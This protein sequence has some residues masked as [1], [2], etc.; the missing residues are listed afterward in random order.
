MPQTLYALSASDAKRTAGPTIRGFAYQFD[1][2]ILRVLGASKGEVVRVEGLEDVD[3]FGNEVTSSV[4]VKYYESRSFTPRAFREPILQMLKSYAAGRTHN[5][6]L[7]V[8]TGRASAP[9][10]SLTTDQLKDALTHSLRSGETVEHWT[11]FTTTTLESFRAALTLEHGV[12]FDAQVSATQSALESALGCTREDVRAL[13]HPSARE[14]IQGVAMRPNE[15]DRLLTRA[16]LLD[17]VPVKKV[18]Y[19]RW[20]KEAVSQEVYRRAV[21][22]RLKE[23]GVSKA[24]KMRGIVVTVD[25]GSVEEVISLAVALTK[26]FGVGVALSTAK[27]WTLFA[28]GSVEAVNEVKAG[29]IAQN[30]QFND[31][32]ESISFNPGLFALPPVV[33]VKKGTSLMTKASYQIR[34]LT[35]ANAQSL[36]NDLVSRLDVLVSVGNASPL[37]STVANSEALLLVDATA[38]EARSLLEATWRAP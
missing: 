19:A 22:R 17:A 12:S 34:V 37:P 4:Q 8:H 18:I 30:I 5:Y 6:V 23:V 14:F 24:S 1:H 10:R 21:T 29:L 13:F 31:G 28:E 16:A 15:T 26:N 20:H 25:D 33:N 27:P 32:F 35:A 2:T 38:S 9:P 36:C 11:D 3:I 7:Y